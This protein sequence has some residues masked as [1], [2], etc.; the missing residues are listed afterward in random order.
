MYINRVMYGFVLISKE[1]GLLAHVRYCTF[2]GFVNK[3]SAKLTVFLLQEVQK[4]VNSL[5]LLISAESSRSVSRKRSL[6]CKT[7][8]V[9][10][11][12]TF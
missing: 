8:S 12:L 7:V 10:K 5:K 6:F 4:S 3:I 2:S 9:L 1:N 11:E